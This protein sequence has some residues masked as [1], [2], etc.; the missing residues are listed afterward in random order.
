MKKYSKDNIKKRGFLKALLVLLV[1]V[2]ACAIALVIYILVNKNIVV[3]KV[4]DSAKFIS[5]DVATNATPIV[6]DNVLIGGVYDKKW[7]GV[8]KFYMK[9]ANKSEQEIDVYNKTGKKGSYD[10]TAISQGDSTTVYSATTNTN[11]TDE[12]FAIVKNQS[13]NAMP[14]PATRKQ[15]ITDEEIKY[16]K[17][18]LGM[19]KF[20]NTS[21]KITEV[22]NVVLS[23]GSN[24][25]LIF[26]TN[27]A[28]KSLGV[29]SCVVYVDDLGK[30][31]L[32]KYN[33]LSDTNDASNWPVYSFKFTGDLNADGTSEVIIQE[34]KEFEVKYD[35]LEYRNNKFYEVLSTVI[36]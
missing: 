10:L 12:Y 19:Y 35:V 8:E 22:Y 4:D 30:A 15:T 20:L 26:A 33:F 2:A 1:V 23:Q 28:G 3:E 16:V 32:V 6:I 29:Y 7:V 34:I 25:M 5:D 13:L 27:Q 21:I 36:K 18:A 31:R 11:L 14:I 17:K 24:G 9:S